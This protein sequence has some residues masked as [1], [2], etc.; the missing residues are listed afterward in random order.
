M[1]HDVANVKIARRIEGQAVR[2][3]ELRLCRWSAIATEALFARARD[4]GDDPRL[5]IHAAHSVVR[6]FDDEQITRLIPGQLIRHIQRSFVRRTAIAFAATHAIACIGFDLAI[7]SD[8]PDAG[9]VHVADVEKAIRPTRY[10]KDVVEF[11]FSRR[12]TIT[13]E[14]F[15]ARS[16]KGADRG[17]GCSDGKPE[18]SEDEEGVFHAN[19]KEGAGVFSTELRALGSFK[20][21]VVH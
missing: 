17:G 9:I 11:C 8:S 2:L 19:V 13:G 7:R 1:V 16:G 14:A 12:S 4:G 21:P 5:R 3:I 6:Q 10:A 20:T 18:V 15:G